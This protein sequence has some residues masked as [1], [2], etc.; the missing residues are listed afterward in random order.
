MEE[1]NEMNPQEA[2]LA[3]RRKIGIKMSILMGVSL[4]FS[5]SLIGFLS[6]GHFSLIPWLVSFVS[7]TVL[8]LLIGFCLPVR[9]MAEVLCKKFNLKERSLSSLLLDSMVSDIF[10]TPLITLLMV[11]IAFSGAKKSIAMAIANG[12]AA[13]SLPQIQFLPMFL[14]S[15]VISMIAGYILIF[16]LQPLFLKILTRN[17]P[18]LV[19]GKNQG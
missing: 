9:K 3:A 12:A 10:Y 16:V 18:P 15:L 2:V 8:S 19:D 5:L 17:M 7:S 4:S 14:H 6:S 13:D 1:K 11:F